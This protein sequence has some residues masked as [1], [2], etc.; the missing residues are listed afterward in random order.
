MITLFVQTKP[1]P[2][3]RHRSNGRFQYDPSAKEKKAF[4]DQVKNRVPKVAPGNRIQMQFTFCYKRPKNQYRSKNKKK[5]LKDDAPLYKT[6]VPDID[7]LCKFYM[8]ALQGYFYKSD[9][10]VSTISAEKIYG[11]EDFVLIKIIHTK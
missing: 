6:S 3:Q 1:R 11:A 7:N 9:S 8:D 10:Q 4:I 5:I 2:Q